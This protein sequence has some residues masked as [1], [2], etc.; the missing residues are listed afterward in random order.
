MT[1]RIPLLQ[2]LGCEMLSLNYAHLNTSVSP[3]KRIEVGRALLADFP[4]IFYLGSDERAGFAL[5]FNRNYTTAKS[6]TERFF[7]VY[8]ESEFLLS[9][10]YEALHFPFSQSRVYTMFDCAHL[11]AADFGINEREDRKGAREGESS[12]SFEAVRPVE[13]S[14]IEKK[15]YRGLI[16]NPDLHDSSVAKHIDVTRQTVTKMRKRFEAA[17]LIKTVRIPNLQMLGYEVLAL[18]R[19]HYRPSMTLAHR[20]GAEE[21]YFS[22]LPVMLRVAGDMESLEIL[23]FHNFQEFL[24][25]SVELSRFNRA[26]KFIS[27]E[28]D[29]LVF[30]LGDLFAIKN[31]VYAPAVDRVL[32][33]EPV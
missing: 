19:Q 29:T 16:A 1:V 6:N 4:E 22:K 15:V 11:L 14:R 13:L 21:E 8:S 26:Q 10:G 12:G 24:K 2:H 17:G 33:P 31:H 5:S 20:R 7:R 3:Q 30:S 18:F 9:E 25:T 23:A 28:P 27:R 32:L